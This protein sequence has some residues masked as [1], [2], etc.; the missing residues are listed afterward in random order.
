MCPCE[1]ARPSLFPRE[2]TDICFP[3]PFGN[4]FLSCPGSITPQPNASRELS[5]LRYELCWPHSLMDGVPFSSF[6]RC[7]ALRKEKSTVAFPSVFL[8]RVITVEREHVLIYPIRLRNGNESGATEDTFFFL[9][10]HYL[11]SLCSQRYSIF[12]PITTIN[13]FF[14]SFFL[15]PHKLIKHVSHWVQDT[16]STLHHSTLRLPTHRQ[17]LCLHPSQHR[18]RCRA[19]VVCALPAILCLVRCNPLQEPSAPLD[20]F[21]P[22]PL[23][24]PLKILLPPSIFC[25]YKVFF[26][27]AYDDT[28]SSDA[29][30][31][32]AVV[33]LKT[34]RLQRIENLTAIVCAAVC[35]RVLCKGNPSLAAALS[36]PPSRPLLCGRELSGDALFPSLHSPHRHAPKIIIIVVRPDSRRGP[37]T[38]P[39]VHHRFLQT[40]PILQQRAKNAPSPPEKE[41]SAKQRMLYN[42]SGVNAKKAILGT[43]PAVENGEV[44][45]PKVKKQPGNFSS[46]SDLYAGPQGPG[47]VT[48]GV[49]RYEDRE[50]DNVAYMLSEEAQA[51]DNCPPRK[52]NLGQK[53]LVDNNCFPLKPEKPAPCG[54]KII[55]GQD[56]MDAPWYEDNN[57]KP[58]REGDDAPLAGKK[59][60]PN[61]YANAHDTTFVYPPQQVH[62][63]PPGGN[64]K[65]QSRDVTNLARYSPEQLAEKPEIHGHFGP[66]KFRAPEMDYPVR[67]PAIKQVHNRATACHDVMGTE[68]FGKAEEPRVSGVAKTAFT[69]KETKQMMPFP[70]PP[71]QQARPVKQDKLFRY[72]DPNMDDASQFVDEKKPTGKGHG[73]GKGAN[74]ESG[75]HWAPKGGKGKGLYSRN[76][77]ASTIPM[78]IRISFTMI[79]FTIVSYDGG[80]EMMNFVVVQDGGDIYIYKYMCDDYFFYF[81]VLLSF[82]ILFVDGYWGT[83]DL[84][85][86]SN[87]RTPSTEKGCETTSTIYFCFIF[88]KEFNRGKSERTYNTLLHQNKEEKEEEEKKK[89]ATNMIS[90]NLRKESITQFHMHAY[91]LYPHFTPRL[92]FIGNLR[93][94]FIFPFTP[95]LSLKK[96]TTATLQTMPILQQ[97]AKNAP[98]PP[99]KEM[100]AKQRML[101]NRSGVNAKKAILG[102]QPAV[103][104]GEVV[105][106]KVKKQPSNF[107]SPSDLYAGPQ[108]PGKVTG[109]VRRYEDRESDKV[110]Y[111][112]SEEAQAADNCPPRKKNLGQKDLVDNNCFPLKPEKPA[113]CGVKIIKGQDPMDAPWYEDNNPKPPREGDDGPLAG[114]KIF[115][116]NYANAHDTTFVYPPQQVHKPPPGG[117]RKNQSRDVTNLARYSPE[118]LAEKPEIHGHFGPVKFRAPEMDYPVRKP[119]IKQVH[120]R[121][122][123][124]HDVMGTERFGKAEEPRVSGVA[125]TAFTPKETKQMMPFPD[126]PQQQA[127]PVK[128]DKLFRYYDPNMDDASQFVDEK[129]PTGKGH[130]KGKGANYE[131]GSHWAPKGGK[132]KGNIYCFLLLFFMLYEILVHLFCED[133]FNFFANG[134]GKDFEE[135]DAPWVVREFLEKICLC[136][137]S[138]VRAFFKKFLTKNS[139]VECP[140]LVLWIVYWL[141]GCSITIL[142]L[143]LLILLLFILGLNTNLNF[144]AQYNS[145]TQTLLREEVLVTGF[146]FLSH[147]RYYRLRVLYALARSSTKRELSSFN[148]PSF[149]VEA[150][151]ASSFSLCLCLSLSLFHFF[152]DGKAGVRAMQSDDT[153][154]SDAAASAAVV[155][156]KTQRLQRI[157]NLTAILCAAVVLTGESF[158]RRCPLS[159]TVAALVVWTGTLWRCSVS[160]AAFSSSVAEELL[161]AVAHPPHSHAPKI[162]IIVVRPDSRRGPLTGPEVHHR[163]LQTMPILQQR[164]KNAPPPPEKEMSAKQRM[165]YNRSGVNAKK[166]ILG[167]QPA[168]ENGEV[169]KPKVKKQ[170]GNFSSPSDLYAGP[171]GPGKVTGGVRRYEDRESDNVAYMLSEEAQAADN[172][173]PRKKNL[174]QKDLVDNNCFPL[175]PEKPAPC[176][177]KIIKGQ[178]P[179][180]A[181]WYED[182]NPKPPREGDDAPLAGKKI[183]PNNYANAHDT[184][185]VYPPQQVHKP[186]PGGN[187]KNQSRDV[188]NLARYSPEQLAEKPEIH[189]HFGP[190]KFRA[191]EMDYPVRKPAIKQVHNRATACHDVMGTERFGKAEEPRVSG[192][193]KTAFTPK[194]TKQMMPFPDPP[195][196]QARPV[197]QDKLFR[198]YDPNMDDASQ[199]VDEKKPTG[200]GHGKGKGANY[201]SGSHWAP[202]GGKGKGL[203]SR[204]GKASTIPMA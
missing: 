97:R 36:H 151:H 196:Q 69:P 14:L 194:E 65:N 64:R 124:C 158:A 133:C 123:A 12:S 111:M 171:Q 75:S 53:D 3:P 117:N 68:R 35:A 199:F 7:L 141:T 89:R 138:A 5:H 202:K 121:A 139:S 105:K 157:E 154:S 104:N 198:Y 34:Q 125:K 47:K 146:S 143:F 175:K 13:K 60:F 42:R 57:P 190:V 48:G 67:K 20:I 40:M 26:Y 181:P 45:K 134:V 58:P 19:G 173:P 106:P 94:L 197:K 18:V 166:A 132:G 152:S 43:Q 31:S 122:T 28:W 110:A 77:K 182:N 161:P 21:S 90:E 186:P 189:G 115:P 167:T 184:T 84:L 127:R 46:P 192:V 24:F 103:E 52:K 145:I 183:F 174:G 39:E 51:A 109:G 93:Q 37:L 4:L 81:N 156:L 87:G 165:L 114:K 201:E 116:N 164:A 100:S 203:Y 148:P 107:S 149:Y 23:A 170:P 147:H 82:A 140:V 59:I 22:A 195:Q 159:P 9:L 72:Y 130:G 11:N 176:G 155:L 79:E 70:D 95:I 49:R 71:Q 17:C 62:K 30:A 98:P 44:V 38:G 2:K 169:V 96:K 129:K 27:L 142:F 200:K 8:H 99:E 163:F 80:I 66:V 78:A 54:V 178:D 118:Q 6:L 131:S 119:A 92:E 85:E 112:L 144:I 204:N 150:A 185:F 32:A 102:T 10:F 136:L 188:T 1:P 153:W 73:K 61:N 128:Q 137:G 56:P 41:M 83:G 76:G 101:Y 180:D 50:S 25:F 191:P 187:R 172:C 16:R 177:V 120:N 88:V 74:Y 168:V 126:P 193:A 33:L 29:A 91:T 162:I 55:K 108:G 160:I 63:P 15:F 179:M 135:D 113:P 86:G